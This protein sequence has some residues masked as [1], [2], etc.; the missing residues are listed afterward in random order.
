MNRKLNM[1]KTCHFKANLN[2][3]HFMYRYIV[4]I[5]PMPRV[6]MSLRGMQWLRI[7]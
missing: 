5:M 7:F 4:Y 2:N 3:R 1:G 6:M